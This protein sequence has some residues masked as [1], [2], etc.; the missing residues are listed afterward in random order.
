MH[1]QFRAKFARQ[2]FFHPHREPICF[3]FAKKKG[4]G[5]GNFLKKKNSGA[6]S[7]GSI[8]RFYQLQV[9]NVN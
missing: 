9:N 5:G 3:V 7:V 8:I 6:A 2:F 1:G 4:G